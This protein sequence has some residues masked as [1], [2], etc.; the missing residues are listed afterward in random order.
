[1]IR[2]YLHCVS[3][4]RGSVYDLIRTK[5]GQPI[6]IIRSLLGKTLQDYYEEFILRGNEMASYVRKIRANKIAYHIWADLEM[7]GLFITK[8]PSRQEYNECRRLYKEKRVQE[9]PQ[10]AVRPIRSQFAETI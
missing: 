6:V 10:V 5:K 9:R 8:V 3:D 4:Y 1:M 2:Q 7:N